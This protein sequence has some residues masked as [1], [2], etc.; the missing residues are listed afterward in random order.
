MVLAREADQRISTGKL[1]SPSR[2]DNVR[3]TSEPEED[4]LFTVDVERMEQYP[5]H[6]DGGAGIYCCAKSD[7]C[8]TRARKRFPAAP[9]KQNLPPVPSASFKQRTKQE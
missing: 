9:A 7:T 5:I 2:C 8:M 6:G 1:L 3:A 4:S